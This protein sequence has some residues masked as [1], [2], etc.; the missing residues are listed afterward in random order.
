M[1]ELSSIMQKIVDN[2]EILNELKTNIRNKMVIPIVEQEAY[3]YN[4]AYRT[5]TDS[6]SF[7]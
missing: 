3:A 6:D 7:V 2:P 1:N 4:L 5:L